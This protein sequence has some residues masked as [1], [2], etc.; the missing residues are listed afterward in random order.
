MNTH[1]V[2]SDIHRSMLKSQEG[3][4]DKNTLVDTCPLFIGEWTLIVA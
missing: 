1:T 2:V 4:N 3:T